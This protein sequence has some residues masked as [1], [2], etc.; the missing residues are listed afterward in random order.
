MVWC[1]MKHKDLTFTIW[2]NGRHV[3]SYLGVRVSNLGSVTRYTD[4]IFIFSPSLSTQVLEKCLKMDHDH[5]HNLSSSLVT[6]I[7]PSSIIK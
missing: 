4:R 3:V 1:L 6:A 7:L 2:M 5:F